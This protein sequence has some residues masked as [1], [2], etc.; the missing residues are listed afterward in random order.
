MAGK[1]TIPLQFEARFG[2]IGHAGIA[3][4][5]LDT[6]RIGTIEMTEEIETLQ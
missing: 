4:R 3:S 6:G 2:N 5:R 1:G